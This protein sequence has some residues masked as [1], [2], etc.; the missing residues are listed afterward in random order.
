M[1]KD[2]KFFR[3]VLHME[4]DSFATVRVVAS[5]VLEH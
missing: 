2:V 5:L 4:V 3:Q 1:Y